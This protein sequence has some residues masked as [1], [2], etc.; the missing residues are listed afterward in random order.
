MTIRKLLRELWLNADYIV[1]YK[2]W[3]KHDIECCLI[4]RG[5]EPTKRNIDTIAG[6]RALKA[7]SD[8]T[9][10]DWDIIFSAIDAAFGR[11]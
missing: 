8:C 6:D 11:W 2:I 1:A 10:E 7:L 4:E 9:D 3:T 5:I